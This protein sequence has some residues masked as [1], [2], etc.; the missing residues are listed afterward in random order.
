MARRPLQRKISF[1]TA[2]LFLAFFLSSAPHLVH[3][4]FDEAQAAQCPA[5]SAAK[6]CHFNLTVSTSATIAQAPPTKAILSL[7]TWVSCFLPLPFSNR[8]PPQA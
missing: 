1:V 7:E 6:G 2:T 4:S 3:H 8:A 5:F